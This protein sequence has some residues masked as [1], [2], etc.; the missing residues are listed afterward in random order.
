VLRE[1][2]QLS[3]MIEV[4]AGAVAAQQVHIAAQTVIEQVAIASVIDHAISLV[5]PAL[6]ARAIAVV[7]GYEPLADA[8]VDRYKLV[9]VLRSL[10]ANAAEADADDVNGANGAHAPRQLVVRAC[11]SEPGGFAITIHD[12]GAG[13]S[14]AQLATLFNQRTTTAGDAVSLHTA[15]CSVIELDGTLTADSDG[16]GR[17]TTFRLVLPQAPLRDRRDQRPI[18]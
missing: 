13:L 10:M 16:I 18:E 8:M 12:S 17:G 2:E 14:P 1:L 5:Q 11:A 15:A 7:R 9:R 4:V 6:A 3:G